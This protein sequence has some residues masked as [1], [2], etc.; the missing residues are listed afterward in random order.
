MAFLR[1]FTEIE[2]P[3]NE[4]ESVFTFALNLKYTIDDIPQPGVM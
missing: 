3:S 2:D 4:T 1:S